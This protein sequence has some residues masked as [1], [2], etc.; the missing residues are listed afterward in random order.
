MRHNQVMKSIQQAERFKSFLENKGLAV[1]TVPCGL[2]RVR[3]T[4]KSSSVS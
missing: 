2:D 1:S 4:G 3:I